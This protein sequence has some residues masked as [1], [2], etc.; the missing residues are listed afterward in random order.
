MSKE[1]IYKC[2]SCG[3][4]LSCYSEDIQRP[5]WSIKLHDTAFMIPET[6]MPVK[7]KFSGTVQLCCET[8]L[9]KFFNGMKENK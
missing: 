7:E 8:C 3:R 2:D 4:M 6:W 9:L 1:P 5:H